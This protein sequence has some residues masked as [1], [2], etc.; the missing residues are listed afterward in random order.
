MRKSLL[1]IAD[2]AVTKLV[3]ATDAEASSGCYCGG[4]SPDGGLVLFYVCYNAETK[5]WGCVNSVCEDG[6]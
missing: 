5:T 4:C 2:R 6:V 1:K 3:P